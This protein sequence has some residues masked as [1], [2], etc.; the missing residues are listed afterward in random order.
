MALKDLLTA[1]EAD[2]DAETERLRTATE[3]EALRIVEAAELEARAFERDAER[4]DEADHARTL[5]R[6]R[7]EAQLAAAATLRDAYEACVTTL[8]GALRDR[9]DTLRETDGYPAVLRATIEESL[10]ALPAASRLRVDRRDAQLARTILDELGVQLE[11]EP[12]LDTIGGVEAVAG[13]GRTVLNTLEERL[14]NAE[15]P[16]RVLAG[17]LLE[18]ATERELP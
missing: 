9:L 13:D 10:A 6:R 1:L 8:R 15:A 2:A 14:R 11:L 5:E 3:A 4:A 17:T 16:L 12:G 7:A 18:P